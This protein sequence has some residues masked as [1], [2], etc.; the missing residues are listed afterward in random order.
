MLAFKGNGSGSGFC[1]Q[2]VFVGAGPSESEGSLIQIQNLTFGY[3]G[4]SVNVFSDLSFNMDSDWRLGLVGCNG[5]GKSTLMRLLE[6]TLRGPGNIVSSVSF[7]YFPFDMP[8]E[9]NAPGDEA[10]CSAV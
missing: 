9:L 5:R 2:P 6:G 1:S 3:P 10:G 7:D 4:S 8:G